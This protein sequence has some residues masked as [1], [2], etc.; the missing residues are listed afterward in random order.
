MII[1]KSQE[2]ILSEEIKSRQ[3]ARKQAGIPKNVTPEMIY[4]AQM[5]IIE[6]QARQENLLRELLARR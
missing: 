1:K 6:N 2:E 3:L 5:D 4:Q